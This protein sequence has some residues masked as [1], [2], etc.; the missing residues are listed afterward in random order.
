MPSSNRG[1]PFRS[2]CVHPATGLTPHPRARATKRGAR[3]RAC[4]LPSLLPHDASR[5]LPD[6]GLGAH[7]GDVIVQLK[8]QVVFVHDNCDRNRLLYFGTPRAETDL[9]AS[10]LRR[11]P[12][13]PSKELPLA[14][15][16]ASASGPSGHIAWNAISPPSTCGGEQRGDI[17]FRARKRRPH[18]ELLG[19]VFD[20]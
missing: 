14:R 13:A 6:T 1:A 16:C 15:C 17:L 18:C 7:R 4:F 20:G 2:P 19:Q 3:Y 10:S 8:I 9:A 11:P 5:T 12:G